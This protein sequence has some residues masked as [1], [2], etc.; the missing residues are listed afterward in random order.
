MGDA[1]FFLEP[2]LL[3]LLAEQVFDAGGHRVE[4]RG[5]LAELILGAN[6]NLVRE[7]AVADAFGAG[8]QL[9]DRTGNRT[10][11]H[12]TENQRQPL[13]DQKQHADHQQ[14][15]QQALAEALSA[16]R[17][18]GNAPVDVRNAQLHRRD[19]RA[20]L[21]RRPVALFEEGD[22]RERQSVRARALRAESW[23]VARLK[24]MDIGRH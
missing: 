9:V 18:R 17:R 4:R 16:G 11:Q 10:R 1:Q 21:T 3:G 5:Q 23:R 20:G 6:R 19:H 8:K 7:V 13:D 22:R 2:F 12:E 24:R 14:Q 15:D